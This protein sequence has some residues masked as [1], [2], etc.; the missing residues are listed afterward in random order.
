MRSPLDPSIL[1]VSVYTGDFGQGGDH[2]VPWVLAVRAAPLPP[3]WLRASAAAPASL[4]LAPG[5]TDTLTVKLDAEGLAVGAYAGRVLLRRD[6]PNGETVAE[7]PVAL[8]VT[9]GTA[10]EEG[11]AEASESSSL[12]V[13]PNPSAGALTVALTLPEAAEMSVAVFDVLGREVAVLHGGRLAAGKHRLAFDAA[14][15]VPGV[16]VVRAA[17]DGVRAERVFTVVR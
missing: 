5:A 12:A 13:Y 10:S 15:L 11:T 6:G 3:R 14:R 9:E 8:T 7:V 4:S 16:Y 17:G 1:Y 2:T